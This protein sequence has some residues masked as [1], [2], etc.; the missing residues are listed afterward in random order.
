MSKKIG[1]ALGVVSQIGVLG[2]MRSIGLSPLGFVALAGLVIVPAFVKDEYVLRLLVV[3][4]LY[5]CQ[6]MAFDFTDGFIG[7]CNFGFA[8][9]VGVGGYTS[10]LLVIK[11]GATP[12]AGLV[13]AV[14][15]AGSLGFLTGILTLRLSGLYAAVMAWFV[16]MTLAALAA[17]M[18]DLTRGNLGLIVPSYFNTTSTRPYL[19]IMLLITVLIYVALEVVVHSHVGLAFR[20]IGQNLSAARAS[21]VDPT[22]YKVMNFTISCAIAGLLGAFYA[23]FVG[24]LTPGVLASSHTMEVLVLSYIGG[25]G[26]IWGGLVTA[27]LLIPVFEYLKPLMAV[28][29]LIYGVVLILMMYYPGGIVGLFRRMGGLIRSKV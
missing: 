10:A 20:A 23:H 26:T 19:Y 29:L 27:F 18:V 16:G 22:K 2:R 28:R 4:L 14:I 25:R 15:V 17:V 1:H 11:L 9:F 13:A 5:G 7:V 6:A 24:V 12:W 8:A 3:S 21:G